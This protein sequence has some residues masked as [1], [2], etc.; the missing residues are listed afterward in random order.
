MSGYLELCPALT[1]TS[2]SPTANAPRGSKHC[3]NIVF[4]LFNGRSKAGRSNI[5]VNVFLGGV[6][7]RTAAE[8]IQEAGDRISMLPQRSSIPSFSRFHKAAKKNFLKAA[9]LCSENSMEI[10]HHVKGSPQFTEQQRPLSA[11]QMALDKPC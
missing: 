3:F 1:G 4:T 10:D 9:E 5:A 8:T 2:E 7:E 6:S 11:V